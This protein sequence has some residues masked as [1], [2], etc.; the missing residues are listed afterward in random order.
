MIDDVDEF[1]DTDEFATEAD[2]TLDGGV[3]VS[4]AGIFDAPTFSTELGEYQFETVQPRFMAPES[5]VRDVRVN[6]QAVISGK[7]YDVV[8]NPHFDGS[9]LAV[10]ELAPTND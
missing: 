6:D 8:E 7:S 2:F 3:V 1:F 5:L 10:V 4:V 9:G